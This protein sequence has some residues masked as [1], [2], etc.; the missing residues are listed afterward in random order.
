M[1][2]RMVT[3]GVGDH[4]DGS[5]PLRIKPETESGKVNPVP[6]PDLHGVTSVVHTSPECSPDGWSVKM[7]FLGISALL[8]PS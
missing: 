6:E 1:P 8:P 3:V 4:P 2:P 7:K 5:L